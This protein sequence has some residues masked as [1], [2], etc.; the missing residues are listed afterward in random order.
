MAKILIEEKEYIKLKEDLEKANN[1][2]NK[3]TK[4]YNELVIILDEKN[5][6][7]RNLK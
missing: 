2:Y 7:I 4:L 6:I 5:E 1:Y 3:L